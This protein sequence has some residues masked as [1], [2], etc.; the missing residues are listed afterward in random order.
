MSAERPGS[1]E[2]VPEVNLHEDAIAA[3]ERREPAKAGAFDA[4]FSFEN[5]PETAHESMEKVAQC[6]KEVEWPE[7]EIEPFARAVGALVGSVAERDDPAVNMHI[8]VR[9]DEVTVRIEDPEAGAMPFDEEED[10]EGPE[11][12]IVPRGDAYRKMFAGCDEVSVYPESGEIQLI[13]RRGSASIPFG[14]EAFAFEG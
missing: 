12:V 3:P 10:P 6:L 4:D 9:M 8:E 13:K 1:F 11:R 5:G 14:G 7:E 2:D